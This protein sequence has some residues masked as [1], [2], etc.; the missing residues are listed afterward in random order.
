MVEFMV[1]AAMLGN[2][3]LFIVLAIK[4][5]LKKIKGSVWPCR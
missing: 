3:W 4:L 2:Y 5:P 1:I